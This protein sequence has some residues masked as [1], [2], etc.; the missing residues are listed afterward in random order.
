VANISP[1]HC[2]AHINV[3][4][5]VFRE[6]RPGV[7]FFVGNWKFLAGY[8]KLHQVLEILT[9]EEYPTAEY[10]T[11]NIQGDATFVVLKHPFST[12]IAEKRNAT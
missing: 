2:S 8:W 5:R 4:Y 3:T 7:Y 6:G 11:P 9:V 12:F 10:P 1:P